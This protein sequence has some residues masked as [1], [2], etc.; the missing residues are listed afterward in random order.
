MNVKVNYRK[1]KGGIS[2]AFVSFPQNGERIRKRIPTY[3]IY[4]SPKSQLERDHNKKTKDNIELFKADLILKIQNDSLGLKQPKKKIKDFIVF[5]TKQTIIRKENNQNASAWASTLK[6]LKIYCPNGILFSEMN[7]NWVESFK[8]YLIYRSNLKSASSNTYF[9]IV[10]H[11]LFDAFRDKYIDSEIASNVSAPKVESAVRQYLTSDEILKLKNTECRNP[12][13]KKA[14]IFSCMTG[15]SWADIKELD[16]ENINYDES[17]G[18]QI[19]FHRKKTK[20]LQYH[21]ISDEAFHWL[22]MSK[23]LKGK[24]F[25]DLKYNSWMNQ[26]L[27]KWMFL[28]D[29]KKDITFH[30]ARHS[31]ATLLLGKGADITEVSKLL[32][33][34]DLKTTQI[35]AKVQDDN[36]RKAANLLNFSK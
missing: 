17:K 7:T 26:T 6:H 15:M 25:K 22:E 29:I 27:E 24:I 35:Y 18:Y 33:H 11:A 32:G 34:R 1:A 5:F 8:S 30:N 20:K 31:Y 3:F 4:D 10:K 28:A 19:I 13:L 2:N 21:P 16:W 9:N 12:L 36:L 23:G 14:F